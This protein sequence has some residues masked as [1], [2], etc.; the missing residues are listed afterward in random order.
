MTKINKINPIAKS[1]R[2]DKYR[3]KV[4]PDKRRKKI[5]KE[6]RKEMKD[7]TTSKTR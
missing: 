7:G 6:Q 4:V 3:N 5:E 2:D 1:L